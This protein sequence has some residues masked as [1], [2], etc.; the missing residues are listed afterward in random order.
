MVH[1]KHSVIPNPYN[2]LSKIPP[3]Y[4]WFS[5]I[6]LKDAFWVCLLVEDSRYIFAFEWEDPQRGRK[7]QY[8]WTVFPQGFTNFPNVFGQVLEQVL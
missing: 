4:K 7:Q 6:D 5:N 3:D 8:R 1:S 2:L